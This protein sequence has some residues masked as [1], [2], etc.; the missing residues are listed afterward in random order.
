MAGLHE[1]LGRVARTL[2]DHDRALAEH[3]MAAKTVPPGPSVA[4]ARILASLAQTLMLLGHF[5]E[6]ERIGNE[7]IFGLRSV[8]TF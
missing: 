4:R 7:A 1:L 3:R 5:G 6:A 8:V 2:G